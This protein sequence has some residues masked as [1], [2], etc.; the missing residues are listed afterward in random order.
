MKKKATKNYIATL[1]G[2]GLYLDLSKKCTGIVVAEGEDILEHNRCEMGKI[3]DDG[4]LFLF[5]SDII[6]GYIVK[7]HPTFI[8]FEKAERQQGRAGELYQVLL[9]ALKVLAFTFKLPLVYA[10]PIQLKVAATGKA[11]AEKSEVI[12]AVNAIFGLKL[13]DDNIADAYALKL[14]VAKLLSEGRL[15]RL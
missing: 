3:N 2:T 15:E 8:A 12:S 4:Q 6:S 10:Y 1:A 11:K 7:Y 14:S 13:E 5:F 9:T